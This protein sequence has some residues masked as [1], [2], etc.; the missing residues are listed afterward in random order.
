MGGR[1]LHQL[2][3]QGYILI[4]EGSRPAWNCDSFSNRLARKGVTIRHRFAKLKPAVS[5]VG[6]ADH[7]GAGDLPIVFCGSAPQFSD[8]ITNKLLEIRQVLKRIRNLR[9]KCDLL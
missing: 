7:S 1:H 8:L 5:T 3:A 9:Y 4:A 2:I 6:E